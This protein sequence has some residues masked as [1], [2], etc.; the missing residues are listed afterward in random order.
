ML[1]DFGVAGNFI[2]TERPQKYVTRFI[3]LFLLLKKRDR[4]NV[5]ENITSDKLEQ[6]SHLNRRS[7]LA[8]K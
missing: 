5:K 3:I 6:Q 1:P 8:S 2:S 4:Q 7:S